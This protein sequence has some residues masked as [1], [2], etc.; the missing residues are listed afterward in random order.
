MKFSNQKLIDVLKTVLWPVTLIVAIVLLKQID[1]SSIKLS[2]KQLID[3][4]NVVVWP[5]TIL[6][7][8]LFFRKHLGHVMGSL[9]S[10]NVGPAGLQMTFQDKVNSVQELIGIGEGSSSGD[11]SKSS[12]KLNMRTTSGSP[13]KQLMELRDVLGSKISNRAKELNISTVNASSAVL[14]E[15]LNKVGG[16]TFKNKQA[17]S[18]LI[19][20]TNDAN[21]DISQAQVDQISA[22]VRSITI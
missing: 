9:G 15:E 4:L 2:W 8:L 12:G 5:I 13:Y 14:I 10:L 7:G 17:L 6:V 22:M 1:F 11:Q 19:D 3:L 16:I 20:L 21:R 18:A